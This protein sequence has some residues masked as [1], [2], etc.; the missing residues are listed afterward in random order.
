MFSKKDLKRLIIPLII[1]QILSVTVG[2]ADTIMVAKKGEVAVSGVSLVDTINILLIG[3]FS[4]LATGGA[5]V[6][7]Q[8]IG[9]KEK[10]KASEAANQLLLTVSIIAVL[11][12]GFALFMNQG[13]LNLIYH[14]VEPDVMSNARIYFYITAA[15]YPFIAIYNAGAALFRAMGNSKISMLVSVAMNV[16]NV[17]GNAILMFGLG[18]G[19]EGAAL[20]TLLSRIVGAVYITLKL[21]N[22]DYDIHLTRKVTFQLNIPMI[23]RIL[24]IGVPNGLENSIFQFG[25]I[26]VSGMIAGLG[27][28]AI[29]ANSVANT[30]SSLEVIPGSAMSL[31]MLTIVG[32]CVGANSPEQAKKYTWKLLKI[33][34]ISLA[35]LNIL[36]ILFIDPICSIYQLNP[37]TAELAKQLML[38]HSICCMIIWPSAFTLPNAL[39]A[40]NDVKYTMYVSI[41]SMWIWRIGFS[42]FLAITLSLGVIGIWVAMTIDW[43]FRASLFLF[44]FKRGGWIKHAFIGLDDK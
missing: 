33:A 25:K 3:L 2:M 24:R 28:S 16:I 17:F 19:V 27:T 29:T 44:R 23:Q 21:R 7:A 15:S 39:R 30:V 8:F 26:I 31:A 40:A 14:K 20:A 5:V 11:F 36:V 37:G 13:I 4:A 10:D 18:M 22:P 35:G 12:T 41:A 1:E 38:Y 6:C 34:Y 42:Y 32:Q 43:A 9:H